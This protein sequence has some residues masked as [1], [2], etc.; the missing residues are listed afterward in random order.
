MHTGAMKFLFTGKGKRKK[1]KEK[2]YVASFI[3][4]G[5]TALSC[6]HI[7]FDARGIIISIL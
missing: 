1:K 4:V 7:N 2:N 3:V 5:T 6:N